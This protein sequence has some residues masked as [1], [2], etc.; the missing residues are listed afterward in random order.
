MMQAMGYR[1]A[2]TG[3]TREQV[4]DSVLR[5]LA[6]NPDR[7]NQPASELALTSLKTAFQCVEPAPPVAATPAKSAAR[8]AKPKD[9][10]SDPISL[11]PIR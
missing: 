4:R 8:S 6:E 2:S 11:V 1:C 5:Y 10:A 9:K 3:I 7:R